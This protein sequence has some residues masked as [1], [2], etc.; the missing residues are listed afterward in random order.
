MI[1]TYQGWS[2]KFLPM[3]YIKN[4]VSF[5]RDNNIL[6]CFD[7]VQSGFYRTGNV[8]FGYE[9]YGVQ[10]DLICIG[11]AIGGGLPLSGVLGIEEIL[12]TPKAG[13]MSS[14]HSANPMSCA[15][16]LAILDE[17]LLTNIIKE[18][19][20]KAFVLKDYCFNKIEKY[21]IVDTIRCMGLL[22]AID[23]KSENIANSICRESA[24]RGLLIVHTGKTTIKIGPPLYISIKNLK[25][26]LDI[27]KGV[28]NDYWN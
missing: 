7:E 17:I 8:M 28:I 15:A 23:F 24:K 25:K 12:N 4:L 1:E 16:G 2:A 13:E 10:P 6:V 3:E 5:A 26:G 20:E 9:H 14:T 22:C 27:L 11:K 18:I 19:P 21:D